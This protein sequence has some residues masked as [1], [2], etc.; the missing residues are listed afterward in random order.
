MVTVRRDADTDLFELV[1][2]QELIVDANDF[3]KAQ[4]LRGL[5][6]NTI[7]AYAFDLLWLYRWLATTDLTVHVLAEPDLIGFIAAQRQQNAAPAS[8]N[9]RLTTA[10]QLY[11]FC[12]G[13]SMPRG[14]RSTSPSPHYKGRGRA[15]PLGLHR[16][17]SVRPQLRVRVPRKVVEP[18]TS[19]EVRSFLRSL[20]RYR[21][22]AIVYLMLLC[23]LRS[24]EVLRVQLL[25]VVWCDRRLR[26][27]GKGG[28][29]R[30][31]PLP[32]ICLSAVS[33][34][35]DIERPR[36]TTP[37]LFVVL[38]GPTRGQP[39][40]PSGLRSLFRQRR[41]SPDLVRANAHRFRH[42]FGADMARSGVRLPVLQQMMGHAD[43]NMTLRYI[44][45]SMADIAAEYKRAIA[46]IKA[47]Y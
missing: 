30:V 36:C 12:T 2:G 3:L 33:D 26:I 8:I 9:R 28:R 38:Q 16:G 13:Q 1:D 7:R 44:Q 18:L 29:E 17:R 41:L 25:D 10:R 24:C 14:P 20:Q 6:P 45:L 11:R 34:Y 39:M 15:G 37:K 4:A 35:L 47:R 27:R 46:V 43:A 5:A 19:D 21:D 23:G 22:L 40:T 32:D 31:M 42:T